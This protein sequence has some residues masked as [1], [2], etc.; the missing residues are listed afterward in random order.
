MKDAASS[1][2]WFGI[3][4]EYFLFVRT[5]TTYSWPLGWPNGGFPY[6]Q[7][8]YYCSVGDFN[9]FGRNITEAHLR[10]CLYAGLRIAGVNAEVAPAQWEYQVGIARGMEIGDHLWMSRYILY[11][12]G[13][14]LG[15]D[16]IF[17]PKPVA[18]DWNGSGCHTNY[19]TNETRA[20]GGLDV[21]TKEHMI[22]LKNRHMEHI[23]VYGEANKLRMT[24]LHETAHIQRFDYHEGHRGASVR[25]PVT[26]MKQGK[27]YYEDR[28]PG[29]NIDPYLVSGIIV[30]TTLLNNKYT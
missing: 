22:K 10:S 26:T 20:E 12:L 5:G 9:C 11:R 3:E 1:D 28:R 8:R 21:I 2:P 19:S 13:E 14:E 27:G 23:L 6:P 29:S 15:L 17:E 18:G 4:Q 24:G 25:I 30:D 7:G 16:I